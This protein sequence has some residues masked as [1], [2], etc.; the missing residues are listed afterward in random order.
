MEVP[1]DI[2]HKHEHIQTGK[3]EKIGDLDIYIVGST[4]A[5]KAVI[6]AYDIFG[7]KQVNTR[8]FADK[9]AAKGFFTIMPDFLRG[10]PWSPETDR[11]KFREWLTTIPQDRF[12]ADMNATINYLHSKSITNIGIVGF[13]WGGKQAL[14]AAI[15]NSNIKTIVSIH[16]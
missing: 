16:G 5:T 14:I 4:S 3:E 9:L 10:V 8:K 1:C 6:L 15:H 11:E 12:T 2:G 13:C 7:F